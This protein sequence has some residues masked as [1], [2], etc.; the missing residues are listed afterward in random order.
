VTAEKET[1]CV[2]G[3]RNLSHTSVRSL[4]N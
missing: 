2:L 3:L 1:F 4:H